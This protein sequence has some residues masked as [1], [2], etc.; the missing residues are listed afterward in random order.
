MKRFLSLLFKTSKYAVKRSNDQLVKIKTTGIFESGSL[1]RIQ[2]ES[3]S[4]TH[5]IPFDLMTIKPK[6]K[7]LRIFPSKFYNL[8]C[9]VSEQIKHFFTLIICI[10]LSGYVRTCV[11]ILV[12]ISKS[13]YWI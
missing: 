7:L 12:S 11:F 1:L 13:L 3:Q 10:K 2:K 6:E 9:P 4:S 5:D 8:F